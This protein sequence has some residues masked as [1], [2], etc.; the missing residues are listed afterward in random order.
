MQCNRDRCV[1]SLREKAPSCYYFVFGELPIKMQNIYIDLIG[2]EFKVGRW[3]A[4]Y[5]TIFKILRAEQGLDMYV[6]G[7]THDI[8]KSA[9]MKFIM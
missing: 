5:R 9:G 7:K 2:C 3:I 8:I 1:T 4:Q 6:S